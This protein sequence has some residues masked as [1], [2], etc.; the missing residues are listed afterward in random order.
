VAR[1]GPPPCAAPE[2]AWLLGDARAASGDEAGAREAYDRVIRDGRALDHRTLALFLAT[3]GREP[4]EAVRLAEAE[5]A[6]RRDVFTEDAYAWALYRAGRI[7]EADRAAREA[8]RFGTLDPRLLWHAGAI[9][10]AGG[11]RRE[12]WPW[13]AARCASTPKFDLTGAAGGARGPRS[14][15]AA[16]R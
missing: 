12:G 10:I 1:A 14:R 11:A 2:T 13:R 8:T 5:R 6:V 7:A 15:H 3:K 9:R 16:A 4:E